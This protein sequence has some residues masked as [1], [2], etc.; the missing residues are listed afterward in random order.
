ML[1]VPPKAGFGLS[2]S[3]NIVQVSKTPYVTGW[4]IYFCVT[5]RFF[6]ALLHPYSTISSLSIAFTN[7]PRIGTLHY[8]MTMERQV[9][10]MLTRRSWNWGEVSFLTLSRFRLPTVPGKVKITWKVRWTTTSSKTMRKI[11]QPIHRLVRNLN[12]LKPSGNFTYH[13]V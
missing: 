2:D 4:F 9:H 5:S 11:F 8:R 12:L 13:Q 7:V 10:S 6:F 3:G 1:L